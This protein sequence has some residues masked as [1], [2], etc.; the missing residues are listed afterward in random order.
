MG[1]GG[2]LYIF[3][4]DARKRA[5]ELRYFGLPPKDN[6]GIDASANRSRWWE[7]ELDMTTA[8]RHTSN[9]IA[10]AIGLVQLGKLS[11][12]IERRR[13]IWQ[14]YQDRLGD[15]VL[16]PPEPMDG[17]TSSYYLYWIQTQQRDKLARYL[18]DNDIYTT[19]RYY[20][21]HLVRAYN[22]CG[23]R[24][25]NAEKAAETTL[26]LPLHQ[27]LSDSDVNKVIDTVRGFF[28]R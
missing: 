22:H 6:S 12:F 17:T 7:F 10:A 14:T 24:L 5:Y 15:V 2:A 9:D 13:E 11:G 28:R 18:L 1:D 27:N 25:P 21:L 8:G 19:F 16:T 26:C 4:E 23:G 3:D 20:P